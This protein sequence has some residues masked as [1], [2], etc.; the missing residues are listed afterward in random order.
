MRTTL[1]TTSTASA[2]VA[3]PAPRHGS[4]RAGYAYGVAGYIIWGLFPLYFKSVAEANS[5][6]VL[7]HRIIWAAPALAVVLLIARRWGEVGAVFRT[8]RQLRPILLSTGLIA[9]NWFVY[10]YAVVT[11]RVSE[12]S[13]GFFIN[14]LVS[15]ALGAIFLA[16]R[17]SRMQWLAI[18][19]AAGGVGVRVVALRELPWIALALPFA[20]GFY[21]LVRKTATVK[22]IP[23]LFCEVTL[24]LPLALGYL[25]VLFARDS[26][27]F[28]S[29]G[30]ELSFL[31]MLAGP[32]TIIPLLC[33]TTATRRL[34]L[35]TMGL[36]QYMTPTFQLLLAVFLYNERFGAADAASFALIWLAV[37]LYMTDTLVRARR[38][39]AES[40][41]DLIHDL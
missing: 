9:V 29:A 18:A 38:R 21:G 3:T 32:V 7:A 33:F 11:D 2:P 19:I 1:D 30:P 12:A 37:G 10:I 20:F 28:V 40:E 31:L 23:G 39:R 22:P 41:D 14:P 36:L 5:V 35:A 15:V 26:A 24:L 13:L 4:V 17:P 16:E 8:G 27:S 6:E 34:P 25:A